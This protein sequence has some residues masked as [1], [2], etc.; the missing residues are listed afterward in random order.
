MSRI[1]EKV[2]FKNDKQVWFKCIYVQLCNNY[3]YEASAKY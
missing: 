3:L 1:M 2:N